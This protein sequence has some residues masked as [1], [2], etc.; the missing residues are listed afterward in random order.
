MTGVDWGQNRCTALG[1]RTAAPLA[2]GDSLAAEA[3]SETVS[4]DGH[5][6]TLTNL[7]KVLYPVTGT[8]KGD[9]LAY[10]A[11][12]ADVLIPH[13]AD[14]PVTRKRW[15]NGV[16]TP[17]RPGEMF[18]QKN[19]DESTPEW[20]K[21]QSIEHKSHVNVYPLLN[22]RATLTWLAQIATLEIHVPQWRFDPEGARL[23][24]D[25]MVLDLDPGEGAGLAECVAVAKLARSI[26]QGMGLEAMPVTSG[27]KGIHLYAALD[28]R[29]TSEQVSAVA[30]EL[31]RAL[32]ADHPDLVVSDMKKAKR[33]G[34]VLVDWSQ[35]HWAKTTITPY[36]LRG[37]FEPTVA[38][39][40]TW[41]E[42]SSKTL[43]QLDYREVLRRVEQRGDPLT[44]LQP[45]AARGPS[46]IVIGDEDPE[47]DP[48]RRYRSMRDAA[49]TPEPV[50]ADRPPASEG[51]SFVI[52]EH[53]ARRLHYDFR[54]ERNGVLVSWALPK[55]V[56]T[57]VR[58]NHLAVHTEDHPLEYGGF[59][60]TIPAG[61]YGAG[62]VTIWDSGYYDLEK[63]RDDE[64]IVTLHGRKGGGLKGP[65]RLA[66][67]HTGGGKDDQN[68]LIHLMK[69]KAEASSTPSARSGGERPIRARGE[70]RP[71][72]PMLASTGDGHGDFDSGDWSYEMKW[73]GIRAI[74]VLNAGET[75]L[76]TRNGNDVTEVYPE[77]AEL[78]EAVHAPSAVLDGEIVA[79]D[80]RGRPSFG[81]LQ[82]RMKLTRPAEIEAAMKRVPVQLM[83]F[84]LVHVGGRSLLRSP[85]SRRRDEL[86][87]IVETRP[88]GRVQ[89]PPAF[90]GELDAALE[91]SRRLGL[92]GVVAKR[93]DSGYQA[94]R[95]SPAWVKLKLHRTQ[96]V[97]VGGWTTGRGRRA[98]TI[99]SLLLGVPEDGEL[100]Y[101]GR[102]GTGFDDAELVELRRSLDGHRRKTSPLVGVPRV[103]A[104]E[105]HWV[106]P[107]LVGEVEF[108]EWT[109]SRHLRQPSWRGWRIDKSPED[110][111]PE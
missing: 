59:E 5:R 29:Q 45:R 24:P 105:A 103:E 71:V 18:F 95:R 23:N 86:A 4:V 1:R 102:V 3:K 76:Y 81:L 53:H 30:H 96:E 79:L 82:K 2:W 36:S 84:D 28:G 32:E 51:R 90:E 91:A 15:V 14:R 34:K 62:E 93:L 25:R 8:T 17:E 64:V 98:D 72:P 31:A 92:E 43:K 80:A 70:A 6:L 27:S 99:G 104:R 9:V 55:G 49:R 111:H 67:I 12:I 20:V 109:P 74:A 19:L 58:R 39:P 73:D 48:L 11:G 63:W 94:G 37:R 106:D 75:R 50:P 77:L 52:Q 44:G 87:G 83:L 85:Y 22:D 108:S 47:G 89:L 56:P 42:L 54:L 97:V 26:L 40:R 69:P 13:A 61:E 38:A 101:V 16:G 41:R 107:V 60:G 35:N 100:R 66:L 10:Y 57:D 88:A 21:R 78:G 65:R 46:R 7:G 110:V 33:V 68:W